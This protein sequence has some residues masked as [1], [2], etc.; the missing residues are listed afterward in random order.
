MDKLAV[1]LINSILQKF[2]SYSFEI[3]ICVVF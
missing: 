3:V 1:T 2:R